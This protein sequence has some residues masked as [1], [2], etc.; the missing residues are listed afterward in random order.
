MCVHVGEVVA[1]RVYCLCRRPTCP[2]A[3][4]DVY[5][6]ELEVVS[7][8]C[9]LQVGW[10]DSGLSAYGEV[11]T[12]VNTS[13]TGFTPPFTLNATDGPV[14]VSVPMVLIYGAKYGL[15][16][17]H[18][19]ECSLQYSAVTVDPHTFPVHKAIDPWKWQPTQGAAVDVYLPPS[20][21]A[22]DDDFLQCLGV[23]LATGCCSTCLVRVVVSVSV[24]MMLLS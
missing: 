14:H 17:V 1:R 4:Q 2:L 22:G 3:P 19:G 5:S 18:S 21:G 6:V 11:L 24:G 13:L 7:G 12:D 8:T 20:T 16:S 9:A 15:L 23:G 10:V